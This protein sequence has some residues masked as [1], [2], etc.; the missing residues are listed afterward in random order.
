MFLQDKMQLLQIFAYVVAV[1][2]FAASSSFT[3]IGSEAH[4]RRLNEVRFPINAA[5]VLAAIEAFAVA[6]LIAGIWLPSLRPVSGLTLAL[7]FAP[8][9][10]RAIQV[11]RPIPDVLALAFFMA[12]AVIAATT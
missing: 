3:L 2:E 10:V 9:L 1:A 7:C 12:C 6:G 5:R 4:L 8:L 11:R